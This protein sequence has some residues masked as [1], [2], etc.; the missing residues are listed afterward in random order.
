MMYKLFL[1][2]VLLI[3]LLFGA[4]TIWKNDISAEINLAWC[5]NDRFPYTQPKGS[6]AGMQCPGGL[7]RPEIS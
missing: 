3:V 2:I 1:T 7:S 4:L 6:D 5:C